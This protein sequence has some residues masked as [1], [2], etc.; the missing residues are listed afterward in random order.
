MRDF[1]ATLGPWGFTILWLALSWL[2]LRRGW[3]VVGGIFGAIGFTFLG[4][5]IIGEWLSNFGRNAPL[6]LIDLAISVF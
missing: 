2:C 1:F 3:G 4:S 5:T 6:A